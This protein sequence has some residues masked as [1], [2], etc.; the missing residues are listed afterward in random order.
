MTVVQNDVQK[1]AVEL[2]DA[3]QG[4][5]FGVSELML[6]LQRIVHMVWVPLLQGS[7]RRPSL[8][9]LLWPRAEAAA[10]ARLMHV[11]LSSSCRLLCLRATLR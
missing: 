1:A 11:C 9:P 3:L 7:G 6:H 10:A 8:R 4:S 5:R 2:R